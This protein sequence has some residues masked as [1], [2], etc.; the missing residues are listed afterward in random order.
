MKLHQ[1]KKIPTIFLAKKGEDIGWN[2]SGIP[3]IF[4]YLFER[5]TLP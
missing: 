2:F 5:K 1:D 3:K 4:D